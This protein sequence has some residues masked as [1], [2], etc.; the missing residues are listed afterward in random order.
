MPEPAQWDIQPKCLLGGI[1][2]QQHD[3]LWART[4]SQ[5]VRR[6]GYRCVK[7]KWVTPLGDETASMS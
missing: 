4:T 3:A 5:Q 7:V 6:I 2:A 1:I